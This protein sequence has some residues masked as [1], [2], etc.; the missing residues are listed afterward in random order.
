MKRIGITILCAALALVAAPWLTV[1]ALATAVEFDEIGV[2]GE[3]VPEQARALF[4]SWIGGDGEPRL[5]GA[6]SA[7]LAWRAWR[8]NEKGDAPDP[9]LRLAMSVA[10]NQMPPRQGASRRSWNLRWAANTVWLSQHWTAE[11]ALNAMLQQAGYGQRFTGLQAAALGYFGRQPAGL[12][13]SELASLVVSANRVL[14][15]WCRPE[16]N[17]AAVSKLL[18][19]VESETAEPLDLLVQTLPVPEGAC[20]WQ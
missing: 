4:W 11:Q 12:T 9:S 13:R 19:S 18:G 17:A 7:L 3:V 16:K 5:P 20:P 10:L 1:Q 14:S 2:R 8:V 15:P 6:P